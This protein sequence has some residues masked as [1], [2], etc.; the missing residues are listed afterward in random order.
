M[1]VVSVPAEAGPHL[2]MTRVLYWAGTVA[3]ETLTAVPREVERA[4]T[5]WP[6]LE[7]YAERWP[8]TCVAKRFLTAA[9][10]S[11]PGV[12][13]IARLKISTSIGPS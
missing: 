9:T 7:T 6:R 13:Q 5:V 11:S 12:S 1:G 10:T 3:M 8:S 4:R 2:T